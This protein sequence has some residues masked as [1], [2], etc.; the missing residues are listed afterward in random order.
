MTDCRDSCFVEVIN[1][2]FPGAIA[3]ILRVLAAMF[4]DFVGI[5]AESLGK[6]KLRVLSSFFIL[7]I[8]LT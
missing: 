4:A 3:D 6:S 2:V 8:S 1:V 7:D 5:D